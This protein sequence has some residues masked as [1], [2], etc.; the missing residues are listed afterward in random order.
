[1]LDLLHVP[2]VHE[3]HDCTVLATE[4]RSPVRWVHILCYMYNVCERTAQACQGFI[5]YFIFLC[6]K[7]AVNIQSNDLWLINMVVKTHLAI[8][9]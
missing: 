8:W 7:M 9:R 1:M 6:H 3:V 5:F 2:D 4:I